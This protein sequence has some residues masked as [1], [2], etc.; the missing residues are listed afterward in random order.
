MASSVSGG[1]FDDLYFLY[2]AIA[3]IVGGLVIG[4]LLTSLIRFRAKPDS[5]RP[6]DAPIAGVQP[7]ERGHP[8]WS[9]VMAGLIGLIMFGLA[10]STIG[11]INTIETPPEEE[12]RLHITVTGYQFGWRYEYEG[13]GGVPVE[14]NLFGG[15]TDKFVVPKD[16]AV[17]LNITSVDVWHNF[18]IPDFR[19]RVDAIPGTV[20]KIWFRATETG[21][22]R[23]VCVQICGLNHA[24]MHSVMRVVT[25]AEFETW[26]SDASEDEYDRLTT[27]YLRTPT[28]GSVVNATLSGEGL[29]LVGNYTSGKPVVLNFTND[30]SA[31][32][33]I[34]VGGRSYPVAG[35]SSTRIY[36]ADP[37]QG[38]FEVA[39]G[40]ET[41]RIEEAQR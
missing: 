31:P 36:I 3:L 18:A 27:A 33:S 2:M 10:F 7:A 40:S 24:N 19:L 5:P 20:N 32:T 17:L 39:V 16:R 34:T 29:D 1:L 37:P 38:A 41:A 12:G 11:A 13:A 15:A 26:L 22:Y 4:W 6:F 8:M 21:D 14:V 23:N 35:A 25:E 28:R 30:F 9:Y